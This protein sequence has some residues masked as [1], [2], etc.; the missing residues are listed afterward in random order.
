ME[1]DIVLKRNAEFQSEDGYT[2]TWPVPVTRY[3]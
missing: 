1:F 2:R 3:L